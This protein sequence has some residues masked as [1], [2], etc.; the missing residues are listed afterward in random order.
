MIA[1]FP[2]FDLEDW[3]NAQFLLIYSQYGGSGL[4]L[5]YRD[6]Q[7]M[8]IPEISWFIKKLQ[9][10]REQEAAELAKAQR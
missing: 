1:P 7:E 9:A 2:V 6:F 4:Q 8:D 10:V 5:G 3:R